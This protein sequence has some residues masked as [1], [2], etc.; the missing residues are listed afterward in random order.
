MHQIR[1]NARPTSVRRATRSTIVIAPLV[2]RTPLVDRAAHRSTSGAIVWRAR[3][4]IAPLDRRSHSAISS[5]A[6]VHR[7]AR[8]RGAA[9]SGLSLSLSLFPEVI[10]SENEGRK[11]FPGQRWKYWSTRSHFREN[12]IFRDSQTL[13]FYG[14]WFPE[15]VFTQFKH[16]LAVNSYHV[17]LHK[18]NKII[19]IKLRVR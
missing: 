8:R 19:F 14:K 2:G 16:T 5:I 15:T 18:Y 12:D 10:W 6:I 7:T 3:S 17:I 4:S 9:R 1:Q 11:W 13:R